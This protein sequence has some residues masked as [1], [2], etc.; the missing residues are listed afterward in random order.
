[1]EVRSIYDEPNNTLIQVMY[2]YMSSQ[3]SILC[4][5][6][7][8]CVCRSNC[9]SLQVSNVLLRELPC[10]LFVKL[11]CFILQKVHEKGVLGERGVEGGYW[12]VKRNK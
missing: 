12:K 9:Y 5:C 2:V 10:S 6:V 8:A 3:F 1:M 7:C 11:P 4:V